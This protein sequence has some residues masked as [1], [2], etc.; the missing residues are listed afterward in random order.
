[1]KTKAHGYPGIAGIG[2]V[3]A[4]G[5]L[6]R[7]GPIEAF[8]PNVLGERLDQALLFKQLATLRRDAPLFDDVKRLQWRGPTERFAEWAQRMGVPKLLDRCLAASAR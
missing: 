7:Y 3:G 4:A 2:A 6:N 8:P 5:L 1:M